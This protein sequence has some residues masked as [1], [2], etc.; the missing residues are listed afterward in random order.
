MEM[1]K[2]FHL[3][4]MT[5]E[6]EQFYSFRSPVVL[7]NSMRGSIKISLYMLVCACVCVCSVGQQAS[8]VQCR[9]SPLSVLNL[10]I[11]DRSFVKLQ[12]TINECTLTMH[13]IGECER[14]ENDNEDAREMP[15]EKC[16]TFGFC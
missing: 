2:C 13:H 12:I 7:S 9:H 3:L 8:P 10:Y 11:C 1:G 16:S 5:G 15:A 14:N 6:A 4:K